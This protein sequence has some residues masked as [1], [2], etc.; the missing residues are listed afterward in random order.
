MLGDPAEDLLGEIGRRLKDADAQ[1]T[2]HLGRLLLELAAS[3][4][5]G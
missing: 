4:A 3:R 5:F 2:R 1:V